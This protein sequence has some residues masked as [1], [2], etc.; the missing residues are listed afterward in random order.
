[1]KTGTYIKIHLILLAAALLLASCPTP[2]NPD[3]DGSGNDNLGAVRVIVEGGSAPDFSA[4]AASPGLPA[5]TVL[6]GL[7]F[8]HYTYSFQQN[9]GTAAFQEPAGGV[10]TLGIGSGW[11]VT[12]FAYATATADS[13]AATGTSDP[14][15]VSAG[16]NTASIPVSLTP[17]ASEGTGTL[18]VGIS[19]P[20]GTTLDSF[21]LSP[22]GTGGALNLKAGHANGTAQTRDNVGAGYYLLTAALTDGAGFRAGKTEVVHIYKNAVTTVSWFFQTEDFTSDLGESPFPVTLWDDD[23]TALATVDKIILN[24]SFNE[25]ATITAADDTSGHRWTVNGSPVTA[26]VT[27]GGTKYA[28]TSDGRENG[29]YTVGLAAVKGGKPYSGSITIRVGEPGTATEMKAFLT[30]YL[31]RATGGDS[32]ANPVVVKLNVASLSLLTDGS[33]GI[34][35]LFTANTTGKYVSYDLSGSTLTT[36]S[37]STSHGTNASNLVSVTLPNTL[38][39][40]DTGVFF[41]CSGL[42]SVTIPNSVTS[43]GD[44][45]FWD[46]I[47]LTSITIPSSVTSIGYGA[48]RGCNGLTSVTIPNSV[49]SIGRRAFSECSGLTSVTIGNSV[50]SIGSY[51]FSFCLF[52][53]PVTIT[54]PSSV[55]SI[56]D[57]AF[58]WGNVT[59]VYVLRAAIPLTTL[60][61]SA[62]NPAA[63]YVPASVVDDYKDMSGWR[64]YESI[65]QAAP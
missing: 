10:F 59:S 47:G 28:F 13:L 55:T 5:L 31:S 60:G 24:K 44:Y 26:G 29:T 57:H 16:A 1:M 32:P 64:D 54:I 34:G 48:F 14:F 37:G 23:N 6:P 19:Y 33:D 45:A 51:A 43:I 12:V 35:V 11:E 9:G 46:C 42:A 20:A 41:G 65:I 52:I 2:N 58:Y 49:T 30:T 21:T 36:I 22:Y 7:T 3:T 50:T 38:I 56:G 63:I 53:T 27:D 15:T 39:S 62:F 25:T 18:T 4:Q 40:I 61:S 8:D 17:M